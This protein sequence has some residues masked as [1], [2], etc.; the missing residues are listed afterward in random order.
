MFLD[1]VVLS[2]APGP[3]N[4]LERVDT[5]GVDSVDLDEDPALAQH[6]YR[7]SSL[8]GTEQSGDVLRQKYV[9]AQA[10]E[11]SVADYNVGWVNTGEWLNYTR[12]FPTGTY[13]LYGRLASG[14]T[15]AFEAAVD[16]VTGANTT[17]QTLT[18]LGSFKGDTGHGWQYYS[19]IPLTDNQGQP[20]V[21]SLGGAETLRVTAVTNAF[22]ETNSY[23]ANFYMLVPAAVVTL[24]D[25]EIS[26][27]ACKVVVSWQTN[28]TA[29]LHSTPT[30]APANWTEIGG[31][32]TVVNGRNTVTNE[33][34]G[35]AQFFWLQ[36]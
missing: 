25:L 22:N 23:N 7:S 33:V 16:K 20:V 8:V 17:N 4:Y 24:P 14:N 26:L 15:N 6:T 21:L 13:H 12:T 28:V 31:P 36:P 34:T 1:T 10:T 35:T 32:V 2:A 27:S 5:P 11:P 29:R 30:L 9:D 3:D 18:R 19:L